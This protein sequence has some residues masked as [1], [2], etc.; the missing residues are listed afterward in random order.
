MKEASEGVSQAAKGVR[1]LDGDVK[2]A[3]ADEAE[4]T[5]TQGACKI[6]GG[7]K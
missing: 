5:V 7:A 1:E 3:A 2:K 6:G 4:K